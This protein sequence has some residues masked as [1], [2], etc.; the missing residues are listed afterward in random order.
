MTKESLYK[1]LVKHRKQCMLCAQYGFTNPANS[2]YDINEIGSYTHWANDLDA[3]VMIIGQDFAD[4]DSFYKFKGTIQRERIADYD[5]IKNFD[6]PTN[7]YLYQLVTELGIT[8][9]DPSPNCGNTKG[10]F[11]T[12]AILCL[13]KGKMSSK[14]KSAAIN[15]CSNKF[16]RSSID[17]IQP[18][19]IITLGMIPTKA[20]LKIFINDSQDHKKYVSR[21]FGHIFQKR[22]IPL[23][24]S[25][26]LYPVY[27]PSAFGRINRIKYEKKLKGTSM[28]NYTGFELMKEDWKYIANN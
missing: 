28:I 5:E 15:N 17:L 1:Q 8:L 11:L 27:H 22:K 18:K 23:A 7:Y 16:L 13:K 24:K 10:I 21:R 14:V 25:G 19:K 4:A 3:D 20:V 12:N 2:K 9:Q 26:F 6:T